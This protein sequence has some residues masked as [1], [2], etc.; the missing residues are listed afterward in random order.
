MEGAELSEVSS[1]SLDRLMEYLDSNLITLHNNLNDDNFQRILMVIW[2]I[3]AEILSQL[4]QDN[5]EVRQYKLYISIAKLSFQI[6]NDFFF[7]SR[8]DWHLMQ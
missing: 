2:E 1:N 4:V 6:L 7:F 3:M 5:L 8:M